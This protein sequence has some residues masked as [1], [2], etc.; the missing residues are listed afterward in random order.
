VREED[1]P[2][3]DAAFVVW[4][5]RSPPRGSEERFFGPLGP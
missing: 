2:T 4:Y 1:I 3:Q 5:P